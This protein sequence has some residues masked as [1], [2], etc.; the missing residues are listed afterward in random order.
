[1]LNQTLVEATKSAKSEVKPEMSDRIKDSRLEAIN[2]AVDEGIK[3]RTEVQ[4]VISEKVESSERRYK[5]KTMS[6]AE[7]LESYNRRDNIRILGVKKDRSTDNKLA[8]AIYSQCKMS[9]N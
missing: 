2:K 8:K 5:L 3:Q 6:E 1:M 4:K 7:L 9:F